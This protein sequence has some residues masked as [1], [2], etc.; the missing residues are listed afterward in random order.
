VD[1]GEADA[2]VDGE[3]VDALLALFDERVLEDF[4]VSS[5]A[6]PPTFSSAW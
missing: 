3:I 1:V 5:S 6:T 4:P 2:G